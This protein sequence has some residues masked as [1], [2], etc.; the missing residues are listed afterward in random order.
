MKNL[1][2]TPKLTL[3][4][5][6]FAAATLV[7]LS[8]PAYFQGRAS[9]KNATISELVS[10]S[11]EK[12]S[13]LNNWVAEDERD[14]ED[15][16]N[17]VYLQHLASTIG[18]VSP[19]SKEFSLATTEIIAYLK[20][21]TG[22]GHRYILLEVIEAQS[23]RVI[24]AT[25]ASEVGKFK[26]AEPYFIGGKLAP[27][28]QNPIYNL[29]RQSVITAVGAPI[30]SPDGEPVAVLGGLLN[31]DLL[32]QI[33]EVRT[34]LH[35]SNDVFLVNT[36]KLFV[37]QPYLVTDPAILQRGLH[38]YAVD[39]CL[40][41]KS[42]WVEA[43]DYRG[44]P[45]IITYRWLPERQL[46]LITKIDQREAYAPITALGR[47]LAVSSGLI[48]LVG[49]ILAFGI[50]RSIT[51]PIQQLASIAKQFGEGSLNHRIERHSKDEI[52]VLAN[53]FNA[54]ADALQAETTQLKQQSEQLFKLSSDLIGIANLDG[55]FI[56]LNPSWQKNL[57]L[58]EAELKS[59][60][61][62]HFVHPDDR[63]ATL[64]ATADLASGKA[65]ILFENRYRHKDG[66]Y[67]WLQWNA[68]SDPET[69]LIYAIAHDVTNR[70]EAAEQ[71][72]ESE[73]RYRTLAQTSPD[74]IFVIDADDRVSYI[75]SLTARQ[76]G[77]TP[78]E[79]IGS[80][81]T[82]LFPASMSDS[83]TPGLEQI[84]KTGEPQ[85][86]ESS[87]L[88]SGAH[89]WLDTSLVPLRDQEG[90]ITSVMG[91]SR[92][93]SDRKAAAAAL[94]ES[95]QRF[96]R[97]IMGAPFPIM[98]HAEDGEIITINQAWTDLTGYTHGDLPTIA[99]WI[100]KA[101][102]QQKQQVQEEIES[103]YG[104]E[105]PRA[106][107][108]YTITTASGETIIWDFSSAALGRLPD[109]RR[110][111]IS[112]AMDV[113]ERKQAEM[114]ILAEKSLSDSV[115]NSLPGIFYVF[116]AQ[117]KFQRWNR[118]FE[119]VSGYSADEMPERHPSDFFGG[120]EKTLVQERIQEVFKEGSTQV[121]AH[122]L[123]LDGGRTPYLLTGVR[124]YQNG[125][126]YLIGTGIDIT[127]RKQAEEI[128]QLRVR[129]LEFSTDHT[130]DQ[131]LQKTLDEVGVLVNS[132]IGFYHF[133]DPD[134]ESLSLQAWSTQTKEEYCHTQGVKSHYPIS[135]AGV[136]A[137]CVRQGG[138]VIHNHYE[139]L[140]DR[141]GLPEG[142][143]SLNREAV[144]PIFRNKLI[145]AILGFGNKPGN[146]T[147]LDVEIIT[148][149]G[150]LAWTIVES[151]RT[152]QSLL[153]SEERYR[154]LAETSP[155]MIFVIDRNDNV[156]YVNT[157]AARQFG[158]TP[159]KVLGKARSELF[160]PQVARSQEAGLK[161]VQEAGEAFSS[162]TLVDFTGGQ[163][164]LNTQLV[165][166]GDESGQVLAVMGILRD[167]TERK[168]AEEKIQ[169]ALD[170]LA[171]SNA[172]LERF[173]YVASHDLQEPL[174]MVT[175]YL[176]LLER[177]YKDRLD[178]DAL[179]FINY[180]VDGSIRMKTLITDLL[181][182]SRV[183]TRGKDFAPVDCNLVLERVLQNLQ[184]SIREAGADITLDAL[185][186]ILGDD[187]Q[188]ESLF[189]NLIG[190]AIK[191]RGED[192][193][194]FMWV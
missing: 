119:I 187:T 73:E 139:A 36:S 185:P 60:P 190:N 148:F 179:E 186:Q 32:N 181:A 162:E 191:F 91:V 26:E 94:E 24:A 135:E 121:E 51:R 39:T 56:N 143:A 115:I 54:M 77:K 67:R 111:V 53:E 68:T 1:R 64:D 137:E 69:G 6:L 13:A 146:Y 45:A 83:Q 98:I 18:K 134:Q 29:P 58:T 7:G 59:K 27:Y 182:Y 107:G 171:R 28:F 122:F 155:D 21:W 130:I 131:V 47:T 189:Q 175:S 38:T 48:L 170:D 161:H 177:R 90:N 23:G 112:M 9:L 101:Y 149:F 108:E 43:D 109:G 178:G 84:F 12:R 164:W 88:F 160:P 16:A 180:A 183:G 192:H 123:S 184:I 85:S 52:G 40:M 173:A 31:M 104:L 138:P 25:D 5:I 20:N 97:A 105:E 151:K 41:E 102:G 14:I 127:E 125:Q 15:I 147:E 61:F 46:C 142:Q 72:R 174:R 75:N 71:L 37:T 103:L 150:D 19:D 136:W 128:S 117:G 82:E 44:V 86:I 95:E 79:A 114:A 166:M 22:A 74:M 167:V 96:R 126:P 100:L 129:L 124:F 133:V 132:P 70:N 118:N 154:L 99:E 145:V 80:P 63:Q 76:F 168:T 152:E 4:F 165:P 34:G 141:N 50:A 144:V 2:I 78:E 11:L 140:P 93:V 30:F 49:S 33:F 87:I 81:R 156:T 159:D 193:H 106:E 62:V 89:Q 65:V 157:L 169:K 163:L 55:Y 92:D 116:D 194:R 8:L 158:K 188:L 113:T 66:S 172:E 57:G 35:Q 110:I 153:D 3:T 42:G 120:D 10:T 176:Q 17:S